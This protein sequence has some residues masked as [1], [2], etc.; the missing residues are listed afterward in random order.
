LAPYRSQLSAVSCQIWPKAESRE[1][2]ATSNP[3]QFKWIAVLV[4]LASHEQQLTVAFDL[5]HQLAIPFDIVNQSA[6]ALEASDREAVHGMDDSG[7]MTWPATRGS[8]C[9]IGTPQ[10]ATHSFLQYSRSWGIIGRL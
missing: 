4:D 5:Q 10:V 6:Q 1:L 2:K 9:W 7:C 3:R 8:G